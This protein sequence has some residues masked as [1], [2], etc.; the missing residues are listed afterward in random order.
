M[1]FV[2][3]GAIAIS[4][5]ELTGSCSNTGSN[6]VPALVVFQMPL[7]AVATK[8]V[9]DGDGMPA[10]LVTRPP[11]FAGPTFRHLKPARVAESSAGADEARAAGAWA[12][13]GAA[14][15]AAPRVRNRSHRDTGISPPGGR[16][17]LRRRKPASRPARRSILGKVRPAG[18]IRC[19]G[20]QN[21]GGCLP[22]EGEQSPL[23]RS[24][25]SPL[26]DPAHF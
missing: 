24:R 16:I 4:P 15:L 19:G 6:V 7:A 14:T 9:R 2:S 23:R 22:Q 12:E 25:S 5:I 3:D 8:N 10:I 21:Y 26:P 17:V 13:S 1:T 20:V 11:M 18:S